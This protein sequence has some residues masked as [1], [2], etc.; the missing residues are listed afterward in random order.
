MV[1]LISEILNAQDYP[2]IV[3]QIARARPGIPRSTTECQYFRFRKSEQ[4]APKTQARA[5]IEIG[6]SSLP[7][8]F[9]LAYFW[10]SSLIRKLGFGT[11]NATP[12]ALVLSPIPFALTSS[13][14]LT[15][16]LTASS[17]VP[18]G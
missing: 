15:G 13:K 4:T 8:W 1:R 18:N 16:V 9:Y 7:K 12:L 10:Q 3:T 11:A 14:N 5:Q 2:R 6:N 17:F